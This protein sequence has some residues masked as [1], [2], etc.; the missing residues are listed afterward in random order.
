MNISTI[1]KFAITS[2][3]V[4]NITA[5]GE[6]P[7]PT[8]NDANQELAEEQRKV[9]VSVVKEIDFDE[10]IVS[11]GKVKPMRY[12]D[13]YWETSG[14]IAE[15]RVKNGDHIGSGALIARI[16]TFELSRNILSIKTDM[17]KS[18]LSFNDILIGQGYDPNSND[19]PKNQKDIAEIK[20]GYRQAKI[21]YE[22]QLQKLK[23]AS[24]KAPFDGVVANLDAQANNRTNTGKPLCRVIDMN[25][26]T[27]EFTI[28]E[29]ELP[30]VSKGASVR[31]EA[32]SA[33]GQYAQGTITDIN[34]VVEANGTIV[35]HAAINSREST[36]FEGM[37]VRVWINKNAGRHIA[38][39][40]NAVVMRSG[41]SVVFSVEN[42]I[43]KWNYVETGVENAEFIAIKEGIKAGDTIVVD[44]A[45][46]LAHNASLIISKTTDY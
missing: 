38:V 22:L 33:P 5:C 21:Q 30:Q 1:V 43:A 42:G 16:D 36:F 23:K 32:Y 24:V 6:N 25:N 20:S 29:S 26:M 46:D 45:T 34:P 18:L 17:E 8:E 27:V 14:E 35:V 15:V 40:K 3:V 4:I 44:G 13:I 19:I 9:T 41:K 10:N 37:N 28:I 31:I 12:A 11:N 2:L 7:Q 39:P